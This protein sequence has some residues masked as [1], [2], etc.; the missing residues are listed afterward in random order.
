MDLLFYRVVKVKFIY[1]NVI[2]VCFKL[3]RFKVIESLGRSLFSFLEVQLDVSVVFILGKFLSIFLARVLNT[4]LIDTFLLL[5][6]LL[7]N[8]TV[9]SLLKE[10]IVNVQN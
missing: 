4:E 7:L 1:I 6:F 5:E 9:G 8:L 2:V 3:I 10:Q